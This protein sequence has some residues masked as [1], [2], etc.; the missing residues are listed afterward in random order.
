[1]EIV[2]YCD[3]KSNI[4]EIRN[5]TN[6]LIENGIKVKFETSNSKSEVNFPHLYIENKIFCDN[7]FLKYE[8]KELLY[9]IKNIPNRKLTISYCDVC[10]SKDIL[11]IK[12][13]IFTLKINNFEVK[14][15]KMKHNYKEISEIFDKKGNIIYDEKYLEYR[16]PDLINFIIKH[17]E[18]IS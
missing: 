17:V 15:N 7:S 6:F 3:E 8:K 10:H 1:M 9:M 12:T 13:L 5:V 11:F 16:V 18:N 2:I 4:K 14:V